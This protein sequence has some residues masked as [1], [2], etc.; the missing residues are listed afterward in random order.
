M[1]N[2]DE[3]QKEIGKGCYKIYGDLSRDW[4]EFADGASVV[5]FFRN[6]ETMQNYPCISLF[7][8]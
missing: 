6:R 4:S 8:V 5:L 1:Q 2:K 3:Y 7:V